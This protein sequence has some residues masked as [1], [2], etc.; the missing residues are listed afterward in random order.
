MLQQISAHMRQCVHHKNV[1]KNERI[2]LV[3]P[4]IYI[5]QSDHSNENR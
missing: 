3:A 4:I 2:V 5:R 1:F